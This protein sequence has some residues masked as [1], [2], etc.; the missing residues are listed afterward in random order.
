LILIEFIMK[1]L[2]SPALFVFLF[3]CNG[4]ASQNETDSA[5]ASTGKNLS[6]NIDTASNAS[7]TST[8]EAYYR[9]KDAL[10]EA[11]TMAANHAAAEL[12]SLADSIKL[13]G[14]SDSALIKTVTDFSG[15]IASEAVALPQEDNITEKRR[16]FS[17]ITEN[18]YPLL[19]SVQ[20]Q[21]NTVYQQM[22]PMA[23]NDNETAYWLSNSREVVNPYLGKKHPK[24]SAGMLHCGE[25]KDS[26]NYRK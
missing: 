8:L 20:Y 12:A 13:E 3:A 19:Q 5:T 14:V 2:F 4:G 18:L 17:M 15:T 1:Y 21:G 6:L 16:S 24:Y 22:C 11:D 26:L 23:F 25:V 9:L 7:I 10:V